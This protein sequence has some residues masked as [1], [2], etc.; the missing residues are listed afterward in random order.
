VLGYR[1][2]LATSAV[3]KLLLYGEPGAVIGV[4]EVAWCRETLFN[5]TVANVGAGTH[6]LPEDQPEAGWLAVLGSKD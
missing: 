6:F 4:P 2:Y 3:P 1:A 5:L